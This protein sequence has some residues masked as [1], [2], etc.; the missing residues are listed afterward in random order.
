MDRYIN[1]NIIRT[2]WY[3]KKM[4]KFVLALPLIVFI[5]LCLFVLIFLLQ[6]KDPSKPP[7][8]LINKEAPRFQMENLFNNNQQLTNKDLKNK[9]VLVNFFA[10]WCAP[11]KAEHPLFFVIKKDFP[12]LFLLG[13]NYKDKIKDAEIYLN[14][15]GNPYTYVGLDKKGM[16]GLDFGVFGLPETFLINEKGKI[17]FKHLGPLD[18]NIINNEIRSFLQ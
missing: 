14:S 2:N 8:V 3:F 10:S 6:E 15:N 12:N 7:S 11:C 1:N 18:K 9:F 5:T 16:I 13:I 4:K 17:V